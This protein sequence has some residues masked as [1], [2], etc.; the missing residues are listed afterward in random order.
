MCSHSNQKDLC[1]MTPGKSFA[2]QLPGGVINVSAL[3]KDKDSLGLSEIFGYHLPRHLSFAF[4]HIQIYS[5][6]SATEEHPTYCLPALKRICTSWQTQTASEVQYLLQIYTTDALHSLEMTHHTF[7]HI[8]LHTNSES[9]ATS[10]PCYKHTP[11]KSSADLSEILLPLLGC[12]LTMLTTL[13]NA[14][15]AVLVCDSPGFHPKLAHRTQLLKEEVL[16]QVTRHSKLNTD[17]CSL[18]HSGK[19]PQQWFQAP[20]SEFCTASKPLGKTNSTQES[21]RWRNKW[22]SQWNECL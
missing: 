18:P 14:R 12:K 3:L 13:T 1:Q 19:K 10:P 21:K 17:R 6:L 22:S 11:S 8:L 9:V 5:V 7:H 20:S 15:T 16:L 2:I 4:H